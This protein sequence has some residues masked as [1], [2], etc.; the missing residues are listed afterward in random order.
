MIK[1]RLKQS[2]KNDRDYRAWID[3]ETHYYYGRSWVDHENITPE[4]IQTES[5]IETFLKK[6]EAEY[7]KKHVVGCL[8][9]WLINFKDNKDA[10]A[11]MLAWVDNH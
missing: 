4:M 10:T 9:E 3:A 7:T 8:P 6:Q 5:D 2:S 1:V 11:F